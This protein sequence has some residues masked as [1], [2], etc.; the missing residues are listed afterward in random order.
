[1]GCYKYIKVFVDGCN[2]QIKYVGGEEKHWRREQQRAS[3]EKKEKGIRMKQEQGDKNG[4]KGKAVEKRERKGDGTEVRG[5]ERERYEGIREPAVY[6][7][8]C[9]PLLAR[10]SLSAMCW[11]AGGWKAVKC[12]QHLSVAGISWEVQRGFLS[13]WLAYLLPF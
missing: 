7:M 1:M 2:L 3:E 13:G 5:E 11:A 6:K 10:S 9:L 4:E 12:G 8:L